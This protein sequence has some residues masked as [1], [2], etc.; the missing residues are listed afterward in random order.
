MLIN[1]S[2]YIQASLSR[3]RFLQLTQVLPL[4]EGFNATR[5]ID[6]FEIGDEQYLACHILN[7]FCY[8]SDLM[9]DSMLR[10]AISKAGSVI[11]K[12]IP[13]WC[14]SSFKSRCFFSKIPGERVSITDSSNLLLS[15]LK[16]RCDI[17]EDNIIDYFSIIEALEGQK[18]RTVIVLID[19]FVGSGTQCVKAWSRQQPTRK[20]SMSEFASSHKHLFLYVPLIANYLGERLI[21]ATCSELRLSPLNTLGEEYNLFNQDCFCWDKDISI[22]TDGVAM[23]EGKS[24]LLNLPFTNGS[25]VQDAKGFAKQGL[26]LAFSHCCPDAVIPLFYFRS[27][28]WTPLVTNRR[29]ING[30]E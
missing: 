6:N 2:S 19:D 11:I 3:A 17:P 29:F 21:R 26:A 7:F 13:G 12:E 10:N 1:K 28:N 14:N 27:V 24:R 5:W 20:E 22:F 23:I 25:D 15:R 4:S 9:I 30:N 18:Q 8:F 16:Y